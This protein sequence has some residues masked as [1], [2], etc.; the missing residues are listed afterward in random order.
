MM[1]ISLVRSMTLMVMV[2]MML[3]PATRRLMPAMPP[4]TASMVPSIWSTCCWMTSKLITM[5]PSGYFSSM[6][7]LT[8]S[9]LSMVSTLNAT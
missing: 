2:L 3:T 8:W 7:S 4:R 1:P 6:S 9:T 5:T